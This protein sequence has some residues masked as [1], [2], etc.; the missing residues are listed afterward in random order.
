MK[1][2][3]GIL[4]GLLLGACVLVSCKED[5]EAVIAGGLALDK[6]EITIGPEGGVEKLSISSTVGWVAGA[7]RPWIAVSPANGLGS[8]EC[9]LAIDSTLENVAR[10]AQVRFSMDGYDSRMVTVTQFGFGKQI[11]LKESVME[12]ES[13]DV[14]DKR[15]FDV[16]I[17]T[18]VAFTIDGANI[19]YAFVGA[20]G[21]TEE[22]RVDVEP[23]RADWLTLPKEEDLKVEL[24]R[25][26]RPRSVTVRFYWK[27]NTAPYVREAKLRLLP[28]HPDED[29]LVD[30]DG[31]PVDAVVL[32]VRQ[33]AAPR[34]EDNRAGDS[35]AVITIN[36]KL[37]SMVAIDG[38]ENMQNWGSVTLWEE[39]DKDLP[40]REAVG[41]VRSVQFTMINLKDG[42]VLPR[43]V[44]HLKYLESFTVMSNANRHLRTVA[45]GNEICSL[46][47]LKHL[48]VFALGLVELP[49]DFV[50][51]GGQV[52]GSYR[53]LETL[54]LASNNFATLSVVTNVVN[55]TNFP[56]LKALSLVGGRRTDSLLD[57]TQVSDGTYNGTPLGLS[58]NLSTDSRE[59]SAFLSLLTWDNLEELSLS[60]NF[61][62]G[63]LPT[64]V[65]VEAALQATGMPVHYSAS[66]FSDNV[67]DFRDKLV[68]D[69]CRWLL[70]DDNPVTYVATDGTLHT[71]TGQEVLR[72][73][74]KA[75]VFSI[76]LNFLT[77]SVPSWMLFH[78][79]F[80]E[81]SPEVM[82]FN[83]Q[84]RGKDS[85]GRP[86]HFDNVNAERFDYT[87]YY[88]KEDPG[89]KAVVPGV[90]YPIYYRR[91][92]AGT[93]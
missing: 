51:L 82:V 38:S 4:Y 28:A 47:Y 50:K 40:S 34:I 56:H 81:W 61:L 67:A 52:D 64:D 70:T 2:R 68:G 21:M 71:L 59:K 69:T 63:E 9:V 45:L 41:R 6:E 80:A 13:S 8:A 15:Y 55:R 29:Q 37:Q 32:T 44:R 25:K 46:K 7:S 42:E 65:E 92:V 10:K 60:Y 17:T 12:I 73:L 24:D 62:E 91:Y 26:A 66:D 19:D 27:M 78:P 3:K 22:E 36:E 79:Y 77:G 31:N 54:N 58:V 48:M 18:N 89:E 14:Y 1:Y 30:G 43:E 23:D 76:N 20:E 75:R 11:I 57:L 88:G 33:K 35:L 84:E 5:D 93:E 72:V 39:T 74:P 16:T 87:Y 90:A 86:V 53:G 85:M 49:G 83:Q